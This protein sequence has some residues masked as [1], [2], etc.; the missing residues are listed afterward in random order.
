MLPLPV[1]ISASN[2][3]WKEKLIYY[4]HLNEKDPD[5]I[6][7]LKNLALREGINLDVQKIASLQN[8]NYSHH[9]DHII[10]IDEAAEWDAELVKKRTNRILEILWDRINGWIF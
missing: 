7:E 2:K 5:K 3:G 6:I 10:Q 4:K 1:N 9:M 8:C